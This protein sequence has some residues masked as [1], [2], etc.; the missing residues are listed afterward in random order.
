MA[1]W[2]IAAEKLSSLENEEVRRAVETVSIAFR[3]RGQVVVFSVFIDCRFSLEDAC[4]CA[5]DVDCS[6]V[7]EGR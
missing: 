1:V 4:G 2:L 6:S 3:K 7:I 5:M